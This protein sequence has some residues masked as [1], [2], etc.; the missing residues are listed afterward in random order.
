MSEA[1]GN[2][3]AGILTGDKYKLEECHYFNINFACVCVWLVSDRCFKGESEDKSGPN[4]KKL[5]A[6]TLA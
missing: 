1:G 6:S 4:L 5:L 2:R 3:K